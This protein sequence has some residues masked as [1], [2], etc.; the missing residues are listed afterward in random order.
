MYWNTDYLCTTG[1][2]QQYRTNN[3]LFGQIYDAICILLFFFFMLSTHVILACD[4]LQ[5][6]L[7]LHGHVFF[8]FIFYFNSSIDFQFIFHLLSIQYSIMKNKSSIKI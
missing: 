7:S 5:Y 4:Y 1:N 3:L 8:F 2:M 6:T